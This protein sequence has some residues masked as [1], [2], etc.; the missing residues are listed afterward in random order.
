MGI[1]AHTTPFFHFCKGGGQEIRERG[2]CATLQGAVQA[3]GNF[4]SE[5][6][7]LPLGVRGSAST[8]ANA[9]G[10]L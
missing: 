4:N 9:R 10:R 1:G 5:R 7:T 3:H 6:M 8:N 2:A